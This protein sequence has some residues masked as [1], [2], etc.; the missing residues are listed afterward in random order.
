MDWDDW[1]ALTGWGMPGLILMLIGKWLL[2]NTRW[3]KRRAQSSESDKTAHLSS[4]AHHP[5]AH[6]SERESRLIRQ[7]EVERLR[8]RNQCA[9]YERRIQTLE[10]RIEQLKAAVKSPHEDSLTDAGEK[11]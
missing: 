1:E 8:H 7:L 4:S 3:S 10:R 11:P 2:R 5:P 9:E 6:L